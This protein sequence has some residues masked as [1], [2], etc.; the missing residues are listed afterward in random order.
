MAQKLQLAKTVANKALNNAQFQNTA[1]DFSTNVFGSPKTADDAIGL[2]TK[3]TNSSSTTPT[4]LSQK[5]PDTKKWWKIVLVVVLVGIGLAVGVGLKKKKDLTTSSSQAYPE[6]LSAE[7]AP[8]EEEGANRT[9]IYVV[10]GIVAV[11][12]AVYVLRWAKRSTTQSPPGLSR[13]GY[14]SYYAPRRSCRYKMK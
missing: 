2:L 7:E 6:Y 8:R 12:L 9:T 4:P 13:A 11:G 1:R 5:P 10:V 3:L 14:R